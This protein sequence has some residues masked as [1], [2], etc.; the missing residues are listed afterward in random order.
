MPR[1]RP[2]QAAPGM[3]SSGHPPEVLR[4]G[5][6]LQDEDQPGR[7]DS[8]SSEGSGRATRPRRKGKGKA[9]GNTTEVCR[10]APQ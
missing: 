10:E 1:R 5:P 2:P 3:A 6:H 4:R 7:A 8:R 9:P